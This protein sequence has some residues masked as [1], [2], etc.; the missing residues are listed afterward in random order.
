MRLIPNSPVSLY[1][2]LK[3]ILINRINDGTYPAGSYIP[4][5]TKLI[6]EFGVSI[7]T[8]RKTVSELASMGLVEK[9][10]GKGTG[11]HGSGPAKLS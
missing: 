8:V 5:E 3:E 11:G 1:V 4:S 10:H 7:T 6:S 9:I 2:Q